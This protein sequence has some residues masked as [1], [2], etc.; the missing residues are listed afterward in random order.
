[1]NLV[2]YQ[3]VMAAMKEELVPVLPDVKLAAARVAEPLKKQARD[4]SIVSLRL[5][6]IDCSFFWFGQDREECRES[7]HLRENDRSCSTFD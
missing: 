7:C 6:R 3:P 5:F 1:M 4:S 2:V